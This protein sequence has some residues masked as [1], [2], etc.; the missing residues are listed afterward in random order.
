MKQQAITVGS[1]D[2]PD[3]TI[4]KEFPETLDEALEQYGENVVFTLFS[5]MMRDDLR[6]RLRAAYSKNPDAD[7]QALADEWKP[8]E[9]RKRADNE[10]VVL[11]KF[12]K[13]SPEKQ[14]AFLEKVLAQ[15]QGQ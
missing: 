15:Q 4:N 10:E 1:G 7:L 3:V 13:L 14:Q 8:G 12:S 5:R 9:G 6:N 2:L 11:K